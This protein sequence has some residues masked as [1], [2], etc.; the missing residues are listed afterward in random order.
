[1]NARGRT[2]LRWF[3][4][5]EMADDLLLKLSTGRG[6]LL[7][8]FFKDVEDR[9]NHPAAGLHWLVTGTR[10]AGKSYFLRLVQSHA[11]ALL[12]AAGRPAAQARF[13]LLPEELPQLEEPF[14]LIDEIRRLR[15]VALG[16]PA[17][18]GQPARW[19]A[20]ANPAKAWQASLDALWAEA[21][22]SLLIVGVENFKDVLDKAFKDDV[23]ASLLRIWLL[24]EPRIMLLAT[25]VEGSFDQ[26]YSQRLFRQFQHHPLPPWGERA[27]R[28]YLT[29]RASLEGRLPSAQQL[30]RIDAYSRFTGGNA[31]V[32]ALL[33]DAILDTQDMVAAGDDLNTILDWLS[34]YYR[35]QLAAMPSRS[36][37]LLDA[38][39]REGDPASQ[40]QLAQRVEAGQND[41]ARAFAWLV[42]AGHL[43]AQRVPGNNAALYRVADRLFV[44]W[45][46]MRYLAPGQRPA[47]ALMADLIADTVSFADK[48]RYAL[49]LQETGR[50]RDAQ[51]LAELGLK[52]TGISWACLADG[53]MQLPQVLEAARRVY[54]SQIEAD[55]TPVSAWGATLQLMERHRTDADMAQALDESYR[56]AAARQST[57]GAAATGP[58]LAAL[59]KGSLSLS[60]VEKLRVLNFI[61]SP[62]CTG[63]QWDGLVK[64]FEDELVEFEKLK[65]AEGVFI[66]GLEEQA[67]RGWSSTLG[68]SWSQMADRLGTED[69]PSND[70]LGKDFA[71]PVLRLAA[72]ANA[73]L[74]AR[75]ADQAKT[76]K[77]AKAGKPSIGLPRFAEDL[78]QQLSSLPFRAAAGTEM[79]C[80]LGQMIAAWPQRMRR[81]DQALLTKLWVW[82]AE[83][84][85]I[86]GD[87]PGA[88]AASDQALALALRAGAPADVAAGNAHRAFALH[89]MGRHLEATAAM[90]S[91]A[92]GW[93]DEGATSS[94]AWAL[95]QGA[96]MRALA[97]GLEAGLLHLARAD[98]LDE[99]HRHRAWQQLA[100]AVHD[101]QQAQGDAAA[102]ALGRASL[103][104]AFQ[105][106]GLS[107]SRILRL[108]VIDG[109]DMGVS[110]ALLEDLVREALV[111]APPS[112]A[113]L[114]ATHTL[115]LEWLMDLRAGPDARE[116]KRRRG[117]PELTLTLQALDKELPT[118][119]RVRLGLVQQPSLPPKAQAMF[120][121]ML[122]L[123]R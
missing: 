86:S 103:A 61:S 43:V 49:R 33:A 105:H 20:D 36:A 28:E 3:N 35:S 27:H 92:A 40:G 122:A 34:D 81:A 38:L 110:F 16:G 76:A 44:Q 111:L 4:P 5:R 7:A 30:A 46:H 70:G 84:R 99:V 79:D 8:T 91:A 108:W 26:D 68:V 11:Q 14:Q 82:R 57:P 53:G 23:R 71:I 1:M 101:T 13:V 77:T 21:D 24:H 123:L 62:S 100:D 118:A 121:R 96:R 88:L 6:Q 112:T 114:Q 59:L 69:H 94:A 104:A 25:A 18:P 80:V 116:D 54:L 107:P 60:P 17:Q 12:P 50:D 102:F 55:A 106:T 52:Q 66:K 95:G 64:D 117:N 93:L 47:L 51:L 19:H 73:V 119:V 56:L 48:W 32:A 85:I 120:M 74:H 22:E 41:I 42:N 87:W 37:S 113:D 67:V 98:A 63:F 58:R 115:L 78:L 2:S 45:Y 10:G 90:D 75:R 97:H 39:I 72:T 83:L 89:Q 31:R 109:L 15:R 9:L 29:L 65:P